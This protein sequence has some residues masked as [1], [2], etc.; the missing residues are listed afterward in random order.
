MKKRHG[1]EFGT[2]LYYKYRNQ[3]NNAKNFPIQATA[4]H[5]C[6]AAL[7]KLSDLF[8]KYKIDGWIALQVHDE[9]TCIVKENQAELASKLLKEAM[10]D[11][12]ITRQIDIPIL[13]EPLIANNFAEA[14]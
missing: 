12:H 14:K 2:Q 4:A 7:I 13:A 9:I 6:N 3:L 11:N 10:E 5:V 1:D 8:V